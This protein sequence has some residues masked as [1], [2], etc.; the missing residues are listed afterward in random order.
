MHNRPDLSKEEWFKF[1]GELGWLSVRNLTLSGGELFVRKDIWEIIDHI[2]KNRMRYSILSNGTLI[3]EDTLKQFEIGK[4]R[5][6]LSSIQVSIDGSCP[7]VHDKSR[8]E[9]SVVMW[10][11]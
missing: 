5:S 1:I 3:T 6:R 10:M 7:E 11:I 8:G 4:R 2:I 9:G